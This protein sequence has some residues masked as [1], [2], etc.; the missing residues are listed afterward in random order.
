MAVTISTNNYST[1]V[2]Y[3]D[4]SPVTDANGADPKSITLAIANAMI[5][6]GWSRHDTAGADEVLGAANNGVV[7]MKRDCYDYA[8][9][10]HQNFVSLRIDSSLRLY[11]VQAG[12]WTSTTNPV[13]WASPALFTNLHSNTATTVNTTGFMDP[14]AGGRIWLF[15]GGRTLLITSSSTFGTISG[16]NS[17]WIVGEYKKEFGEQVDDAT[18]Y[19]HNGVFTNTQWLWNGNGVGSYGANTSSVT[20]QHPTSNASNLMAYYTSPGQ[21]VPGTAGP[22]S[23]S[24]RYLT[25]TPSSYPQFIPTEV[26]SAI[27]NTTTLS[28]QSAAPASPGPGMNTRIMMGYLGYIGQLSSQMAASVA[29]TFKGNAITETSV[30]QLGNNSS[31]IENPGNVMFA[32]A[33]GISNTSITHAR[34]QH[35]MISSL[36][37][38]SL[39]SNSSLLKFS[40]FE[41]LLS[42]GNVSGNPNAGAPNYKFSVLGRIFDVKMFGPFPS[43]KYNF[44]D[45][46]NVPVDSE[47]FFNE[48]GANTQFV[49][50]PIGNPTQQGYLMPL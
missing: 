48:S 39:S 38:Y 36:Q 37:E 34:I 3:I 42:C 28:Y 10:G 9:S 8:N 35:T 31:G 14:L 11:M 43:E 2:K 15:D 27:S 18:G 4:V 21:G 24:H 22:S 16:V 6:L 26:P 33:F 32:A 44:L 50:I 19:L 40:L 29:Y 41:P 12:G 1:H 30:R 25:V 49:F 13:S 20:T 7:I 23:G 47:G 46:F 5:G 17:T 45:T